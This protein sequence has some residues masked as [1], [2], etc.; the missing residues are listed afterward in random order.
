MAS[1]TF[2]PNHQP[3]PACYPSDVNGMLDLLTTG[4]GLSGS[5]PDSAGGGV[6]VG[7]APPSSSLTNKVWYKTDAAGRP[8]GVFMFYNGNWRKVYTGAAIGEIRMIWYSSGLFDGSGRGIIG[9]D[10]DGWAI[11]NGQNGTPNLQGYFP[12]AGVQGQYVGQQTDV[13]FTD[14]DGVAWRNTGGQKSRVV[15]TNANL[16]ALVTSLPHSGGHWA[17]GSDGGNLQ[18]ADPNQYP[19]T[20]SNWPVTGPDNVQGASQPLPFQH[21]Y[22]ALGFLMFVGYQ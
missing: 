6:F 15:V 8:L 3:S 22:V 2:T 4:G 19:P 12:A 13:W 20:Y 18:I 14:A 7:S 10:M 16:P 5:I 17:A 9:G 21:L 1:V 11:C